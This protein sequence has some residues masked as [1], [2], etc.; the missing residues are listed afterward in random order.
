MT[1]AEMID[2]MDKIHKN[3][4]NACGN[5]VCGFDL[6]FHRGITQLITIAVAKN[7]IL[8]RLNRTGRHLFNGEKFP[9]SFVDFLTDENLLKVGVGISGDVAQLYRSAKIIVMG[10][11]EIG[12]VIYHHKLTEFYT[13]M[14]LAPLMKK[15]LKYKKISSPSNWGSRNGY[16]SK[17]VKY[18]TDDAVGSLEVFNYLYSI[19]VKQGKPSVN[20]VSGLIN[21]T[22][23]NGPNQ[24][25]FKEFRFY[26]K[27]KMS[28]KRCQERKL[29]S[30]LK[31]PKQIF[32]LSKKKIRNMLKL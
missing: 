15:A 14:G 31:N 23:K 18:A 27:K 32:K 2:A 28:V 25:D 17:Q 6:E 21:K 12:N 7:V 30:K 16:N 29:K 19:F 20:F 13:F 5:Y 24:K 26:N 4:I 10:I 8:V 3:K 22:I 1:S 9:K 11:V